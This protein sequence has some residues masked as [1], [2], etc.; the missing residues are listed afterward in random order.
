[1]KKSLFISLFCIILVFTCMLCAVSGE[2]SYIYNY[3]DTKP[4]ATVPT[5]EP[6]TQTVTEPETTAPVLQISE[7][8]PVSISKGSVRVTPISTE[9][10][11]NLIEW[12][13][14][15]ESIL[16]VDSGGM[17]HGIKEGTAVVTAVFTDAKVSQKITVKKKEKSE[18]DG[19]STCI[20]ANLD[21]L[22]NN[23][24]NKS[25]KNL[26]SIEVNRQQNCVTIYTYDK[27][28][29]YTVPVRAMVC[30][31]GLNNGTITGDYSL[32]FKNIW[33]PLYQGVYGYYTSGIWGD[34]LFHSVPFYST[35]P[36][37]LKVKE[38]NKLGEDASMGCVRMAVADVKWIYDN[39]P[40][41]T[42]IK[43]YDDEN[44]GPL[45]K[46]ETIR[47]TDFDCGWDPTDSNKENPY[48]KK[49]PV[50]SGVENRTISV[51]DSFDMLS[52]VTAVDTCSNDITE[53]IEVTGNVV[54]SRAGE[55]TVRYSVTD[56]MHRTTIK[57]IKVTVLSR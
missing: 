6:T 40:V 7:L 17:V 5:T 56:A 16:T 50:F 41:G 13:S 47:I 27:N 35:S 15:D 11:K 54:T 31:C 8:E 43:I 23:K 30:S 51:G 14:S 21:V 45:G 26:Y 20:L 33:N 1:M 22:K 57:D 2:A 19:F 34:F 39:C 12:T 3:I 18:Y 48:Y 28:G 37:N 44:A 32:Y 24:K 10:E 25:S 36:D 55:Y 52:G 42:P 29:D 49:K 38:F 53:L 46:P 9:K 4:V